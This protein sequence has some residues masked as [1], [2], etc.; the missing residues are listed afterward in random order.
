[1]HWVRNM[2]FQIHHAVS[3]MFDILLLGDFLA[4]PV[5]ILSVIDMLQ[6]LISS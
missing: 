1:M 6:A 3:S 4:V 5:V 2:A